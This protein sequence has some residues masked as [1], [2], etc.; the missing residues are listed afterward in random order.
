MDLHSGAHTTLQIFRRAVSAK[1]SAQIEQRSEAHAVLEEVGIEVLVESM[2]ELDLGR[3]PFHLEREAQHCACLKPHAVA[4]GQVELDH[5]VR[6]VADVEAPVRVDV[7]VGVLV[8]L[9][10]EAPGG[11][12]IHVELVP[13]LVSHRVLERL[14]LLIGDCHLAVHGAFALALKAHVEAAELELDT[15]QRLA[16]CFVVVAQTS[17]GPL[18]E[19]ERKI[20]VGLLSVVIR[21][22]CV[23]P[24]HN[25]FGIFVLLK[26]F[27]NIVAK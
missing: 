6:V 8:E 21:P 12:V 5:L 19:W 27:R 24:Y 20:G 17:L 22:N 25:L 1:N 7:R 9:A 16:E 11:Q 13:I 14:E 18:A 3:V 10:H 26:Q 4:G 15:E 2:F 23:H